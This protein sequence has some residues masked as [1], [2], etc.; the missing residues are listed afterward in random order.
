[1][2]PQFITLYQ[3]LSLYHKKKEIS[4][5]SFPVAGITSPSR[6]GATKHCLTGKLESDDPPLFPITNPTLEH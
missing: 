6:P 3:V 1:M 2:P 5:T 4:T